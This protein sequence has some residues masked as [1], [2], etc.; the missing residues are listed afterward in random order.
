MHLSAP[1]N[2]VGT[3]TGVM[4]TPPN[5]EMFRAA[6]ERAAGL[7]RDPAI[8]RKLVKNAMRTDVSWGRSA[9]RYAKLYSEI[10][11]GRAG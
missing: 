7:Y 6:I 11:A 9:A 4:F 8:W 5:P 10:L 1:P 3:G 2:R